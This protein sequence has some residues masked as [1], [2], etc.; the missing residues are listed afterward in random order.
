M[1]P[2]GIPGVRVRRGPPVMSGACGLQGGMCSS[3]A[4]FSGGVVGCSWL[5]TVVGP[6]SI[7]RRCGSKDAA[8]RC[9]DAQQG[10]RVGELLAT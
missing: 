5:P 7:A 10:V 2:V 4:G 9:L 1:D 3:R 8:D 6:V